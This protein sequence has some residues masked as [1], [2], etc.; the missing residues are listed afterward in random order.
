MAREGNDENGLDDKTEGIGGVDASYYRPTEVDTL[1]GDCPKTQN[2][3]GMEA[4]TAFNEL[5]KEMVQATS[6]KPKKIGCAF[7]WDLK[8]L[9]TSSNKIPVEF[10]RTIYRQQSKTSDPAKNSNHPFNR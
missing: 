8:R 9:I 3:V 2:K 10:L 7:R 6:K 5:V 1:L 4:P